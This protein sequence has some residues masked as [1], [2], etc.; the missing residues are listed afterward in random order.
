M[1]LEISVQPPASRLCLVGCGFN[2]H[3]Q[4]TGEVTPSGDDP[5]TSISGQP[6]V[7]TLSDALEL[8]ILLQKW[9]YTV[10]RYDSEVL[11]YGLSSEGQPSKVLIGE[12]TNLAW[13]RP[14]SSLFGT[15]QALLGATDG[16]GKL[17]QCHIAVAGNDQIAIILETRT[18]E[19]NTLWEILQFANFQGFKD[20]WTQ[21]NVA[22]VLTRKITEDAGTSL[23]GGSTAFA[24][25][26]ESGRI[27]TWGDSRR[28]EALGRIPT[29]EKR[30]SEPHIVDYL[31]GLPMKKIVAQTC[32]FGALSREGGDV[33][34]WGEMSGLTR[35]DGS[36]FRLSELV[37]DELD[38]VNL[39]PL[40][41]T[42]VDFGLGLAHIV[43]LTD[44]GELYSV[45][46][47]DY[48]QLSFAPPPV[49]MSD[50]MLSK[51][52]AKSVM[53]GPLTTFIVR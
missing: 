42:V 17:L 4:I 7:V 28:P 12:E 33:Y 22:A 53:C 41:V 52:R 11:Y 20:W 39:L 2:L 44:E 14:L 35:D 18:P 37:E 50:W 49:K 19:L 9:A 25:L 5:E 48:R 34:L 21:G 15:D 23:V 40:D 46:E 38:T 13:K 6:T 27:L 16:D 47:N 51:F 43:V 3:G 45:G 30:A 1:D 8:R 10:I 26:S 31:D 24:F 32:L 29:E 36:Q